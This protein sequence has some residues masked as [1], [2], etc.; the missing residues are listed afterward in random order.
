[1]ISESPF[2]SSTIIIKKVLVLP[3]TGIS[4]GIRVMREIPCASSDNNDELREG[5]KESHYP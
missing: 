3:N 1:M 2:N 5:N 4:F